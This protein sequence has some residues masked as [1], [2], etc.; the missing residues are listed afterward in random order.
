MKRITL[1]ILAIVAIG[2]GL[3]AGL[4]YSWGLDS[5]EEYES[6]P[7]SL[8]IEYKFV[9]LA[10]IGD[11]YAYE[12]DLEQA[13]AR[14]A[15]LGIQAD[16]AVLAGLIE[17]YLDGG[18]RPEQVRNLTHLAEALGARGGV[19]LVF[20]PAPILTLSPTPAPGPTSPV[21]VPS[22]D[23][24]TPATTATPAPAFH[25]SEQTSIC[26]E[27]GQPGL[28]SVWVQDAEGN[29]LSNIKVVVS[30]ATG[31]DRFVTGLRPEKG[32]GYADF[33]MQPQI[34]YD[35][36]LADFRGDIAGALT[37][38]LSPDTCPT[39]TIAVSWHL[40]FEQNR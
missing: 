26:S 28:I 3:A 2:A 36:A 33:E 14:L 31:Q 16:G 27:P 9:Y 21:P 4:G 8:H 15:E 17:D 34:Q 7:D 30:W 6:A 10:L 19:L 24:S 18:G 40:T 12:G 1:A 20:G 22:E 38:D 32:L 25:L 29:G 23:R 35:V 5:V 37:S 13:K 39:G 11:L